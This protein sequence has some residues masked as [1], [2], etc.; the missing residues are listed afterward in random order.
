MRS[1]VVWLI[2]KKV[3]FFKWEFVKSYPSG[4]E[5]RFTLPDIHEELIRL[6]TDFD[7]YT[8]HRARPA[9]SIYGG[10]LKTKRKLIVDHNAAR[11]ETIV[12]LR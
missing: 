1:D 4:D 6:S 7:S 5:Y 11:Y 3:G 2:Y 12:V 9:G 10:W 8:P